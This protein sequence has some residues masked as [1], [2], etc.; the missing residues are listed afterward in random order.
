MVTRDRQVV[1]EWR[2]S[3]KGRENERGR[4]NADSLRARSEPQ[5][6]ALGEVIRLQRVFAARVDQ[7]GLQTCQLPGA[8]C[9]NGE[10]E[11]PSLKG[12]SG[13][14]AN[15]SPNSDCV[16]KGLVTTSST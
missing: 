1:R 15:R 14:L 2:A 7:L 11:P 8:P 13:Q 16:G 3:G 5:G 6:L 12:S 4:I 10:V 9:T